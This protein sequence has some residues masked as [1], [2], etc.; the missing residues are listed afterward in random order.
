MTVI[1]SAGCADE[2]D[3]APIRIA[4]SISIDFTA[5]V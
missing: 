4:A 3:G 1:F 5:R 2:N